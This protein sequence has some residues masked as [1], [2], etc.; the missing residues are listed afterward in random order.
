MSKIGAAIE[1]K[2]ILRNIARN[3]GL[4]QVAEEKK[5]AIQFGAKSAKM[6]LGSGKVKGTEVFRYRVASLDVKLSKLNAELATYQQRI[7]RMSDKSPGKAALKQKAL[8]ILKQRKQ[9][10]AQKESLETQSWNMEQASATTDNLRNV[11][12]TVDA[13]KSANKELKKQYGKINIDKIESLQDEMAD[14][15]DMSQELQDTMARNYAVPDD[16]S[17]SELDAELEALGE[18]MEYESMQAETAS[19]IPSYLA[20]DSVPTFVDEPVEEEKKVAAS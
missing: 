19:G 13:M 8:K 15:L 5:R 16:I 12:V 3:L 9:I 6:E 17:E 20:E 10:E 4:S 14:L 18:E 1:G 2:S 11:M 7:S